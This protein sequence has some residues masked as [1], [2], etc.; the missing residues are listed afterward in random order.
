MYEAAAHLQDPKAAGTGFHVTGVLRT[1]PGRGP[2]TRS[3]A[4]S[5]KLTRWT[6]LGLQ[7]ALLSLLMAPVYLSSVV[8][9]EYFDQVRP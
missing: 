4:C 3:M 2:P 6:A 5:D 8:V 9:G 7:G 1:K